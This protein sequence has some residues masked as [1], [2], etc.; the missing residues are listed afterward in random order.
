MRRIDVTRAQWWFG[1][2]IAPFAAAAAPRGPYA[3]ALQ[4][5]CAGLAIH[6]DSEVRAVR[7]RR[8]D[9][10]NWFDL[11]EGMIAPLDVDPNEPIAIDRLDCT[12]GRLVL[13]VA[14]DRCELGALPLFVSPCARVRSRRWVGDAAIQDRSE[15]V[16][17]GGV[18]L[19]V[20]LQRPRLSAA[21]PKLVARFYNGDSNGGTDTLNV[22]IT[23]Y[24]MREGSAGLEPDTSGE[25]TWTA[26]TTTGLGA[27][28][29]VFDVDQSGDVLVVSFG[30][31]STHVQYDIRWGGL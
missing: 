18:A 27:A 9:E 15:P 29:Y 3:S 10:S 25:A 21:K 23:P 14:E 4:V 17:S 26:L 12:D 11:V 20:R 1:Q 7:V 6:P 19:T 8:A 16:S 5:P 28:A 24:S 30:G 22:T 2:R 31:T 13:S